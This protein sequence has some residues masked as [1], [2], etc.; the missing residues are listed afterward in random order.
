MKYV[1]V[2]FENGDIIETRI[3]GTKE[4]IAKYYMSGKINI[5]KVTD[6]FQKAVSV[7]FI[8]TKM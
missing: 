4:E 3:N 1:K 6:D 2:T 7:E 5:G 8:E